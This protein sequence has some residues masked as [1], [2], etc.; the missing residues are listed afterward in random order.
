MDT[1]QHKGT[2]QLSQVAKDPHQ[3]YPDVYL[4][5]E[6]MNVGEVERMEGEGKPVS[7]EGDLGP[8]TPKVHESVTTPRTV[9]PGEGWEDETVEGG[10]EKAVITPGYTTDIPT[11]RGCN[12]NCPRC[13]EECP[14]TCEC[15]G[16][17]RHQPDITVSGDE[18]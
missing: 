18:P 5:E 1:S 8:V 13:P 11:V 2:E 9:A 14:S 4:S 6:Q 16:H 15:A 3:P 7:F 10:R 17:S 12:C